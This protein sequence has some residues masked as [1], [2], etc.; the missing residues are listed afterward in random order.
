MEEQKI[1]LVAGATGLTGGEIIRRLAG[2]PG[3]GEIRVLVRREPAPGTFPAGVQP[4]VADYDHLD[5]HPEWFAVDH[6]FCALGTTIRKAGSQAAFRRV[7]HDYPLAIGR[8]ALAG[9]ATHYLLVSSIGAN[10][11]SRFFYGR[12]KGDLERALTG[13]GYRSLTVARPSFLLGDRTES[14]P[15]ESLGRWLARI[16]PAPYRSVHARTVA[17]ALVDAAVRDAPGPR[18]IENRELVERGR[19]AANSR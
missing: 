9:G 8:L 2:E 18:I 6:V 5:R 13:L 11:E 14:R 12:T 16:L 10:P 15:G 17:D 7:D 1:A 3:Y 4:L 19:N